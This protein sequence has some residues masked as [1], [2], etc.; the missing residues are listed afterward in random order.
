MRCRL[1]TTLSI[2]LL[3]AISPLAAGGEALTVDA[4]S[5]PDGGRFDLSPYKGSVVYLDFWASWCEPCKKS[6]PWLVTMDEKYRDAGLVIVA[7]NVDRDHD[8]AVDFLEDIDPT[9]RVVFDPEAALARAHEL[10]GMPS[11]FIFDREGDLAEA[12][13]GFRDRD[14]ALVEKQLRTLLNTGAEE[15]KE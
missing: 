15:T 6:L 2:I 14:R 3:I 5:L 12:H 10:E 9:F 7:V 4:V 8:D 13:V 11:A 1:N